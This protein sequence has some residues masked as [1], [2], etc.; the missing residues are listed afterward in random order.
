MEWLFEKIRYL[1]HVFD[2]DIEFYE[3][4]IHFQD[5]L[6]V[7]DQSNISM[8]DTQDKFEFKVRQKQNKRLFMFVD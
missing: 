8:Y 4:Y 7:I 2:Y 3:D 5:L 1:G 6:D